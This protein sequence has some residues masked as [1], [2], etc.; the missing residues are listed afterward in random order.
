MRVTKYPPKY[1]DG[2]KPDIIRDEQLVN[3]ALMFG[4]KLT[5]KQKEEMEC[6]VNQKRKNG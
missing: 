3:I 5:D 1:A 6:R 2:Y 4:R